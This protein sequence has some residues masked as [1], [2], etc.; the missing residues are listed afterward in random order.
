MPVSGVLRVSL[1]VWILCSVCCLSLSLPLRAAASIFM[2]H[3]GGM[4]VSIPLSMRGV[5][6]LSTLS[7]LHTLVAAQSAQLT[8]LCAL[9]ANLTRA[10]QAAQ[11]K[12]TQLQESNDEISSSNA[13]LQ[14]R[15]DALEQMA[16][17]SSPLVSFLRALQSNVSS[18]ASSS[19]SSSS[20]EQ[21]QQSALTLISAVQSNVTALQSRD[22][23]IRTLINDVQSNVTLQQRGVRQQMHYSTLCSRMCQ[24]CR[25]AYSLSPLAFPLMSL[26]TPRR[27]QRC[28]QQMCQ[29]RRLLRS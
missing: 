17:D 16:I 13:A 29:C 4:Q 28:R 19:S 27:L 5:D 25:R 8:H 7:S 12:M 1:L 10:A 22:A 21:A 9:T 15:V 14:S 20:A 24:T 3:S 11:A 2:S 18:S 6:L 26:L 23:A